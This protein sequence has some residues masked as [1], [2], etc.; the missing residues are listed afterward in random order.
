[1]SLFLLA[2]IILTYIFASGV[3]SLFLGIKLISELYKEFK[4]LRFGE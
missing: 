1:M 4:I 3:I 2:D